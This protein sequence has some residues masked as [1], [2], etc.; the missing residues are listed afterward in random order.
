MVRRLNGRTPND[1]PFASSPTGDLSELI[2][3]ERAQ[4]GA[5]IHDSLL[6][7]VFAASAANASL[8]QDPQ[9][10]ARLKER[11]QQVGTWLTEAMTTGRRI[12]S[13]THPP[14]LA[15]V[16]WIA[17][18]QDAISRRFPDTDVRV[19]WQI[20]SGM[21][22]IPPAIALTAYRITVEAAANAIR[23]ASPTDVWIH[24]QILEDGYRWEIKDN[25]RGFDPEQVPDD[26]FGIRSLRARAKLIG[27]VAE[28]TSAVG[29]GTSVVITR[30][31]KAQPTT[32]P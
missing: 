22:K 10:D 11:C 24:G 14:E 30:Q 8:L 20:E 29:E 32:H 26:R 21:E 31:S 6:P 15:D 9:L 5:E 13:Q 18:A 19:H 4:I 3:L 17:A 16:S 25:G 2:E 12:L 27:G 28:I 1:A 23:H 7:L